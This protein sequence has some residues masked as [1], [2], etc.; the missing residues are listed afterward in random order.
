[1]EAPLRG[2]YLDKLLRRASRARDGARASARAEDLARARTVTDSLPRPDGTEKGVGQHGNGK[3]RISSLWT[4]WPLSACRW[5]LTTP[6]FWWDTGRRQVTRI[7]V[8]LDITEEVAAE[9]AEEQGAELIVS[10]HPVIFHP[11]R[12]V[13][14]GDPT[15]RILLALIEGRHR[16]HLCPHQS[17]RVPGRGQRR[18]GPAA[19]PAG[20][21]I[22]Q[23]TG[24]DGE[25]VP[26]ASAGWAPP[27]GAP[28]AYAP[29][30]PP[31]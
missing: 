29:G 27:S 31:L 26:T 30:S 11:A 13:T 4:R 17:G 3:G 1:M 5:S 10:H 25:A 19:G 7:L 15:G 22:V 12:A 2:A 9:E 20:H 21:R 23:R 8:S 28:T 6:A 14:D 18:P 24:G 16:R